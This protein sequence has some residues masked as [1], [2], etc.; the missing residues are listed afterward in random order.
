MCHFHWIFLTIEKKF[1]LL[2]YYQITFF[3]FVELLDTAKTKSGSCVACGVND[4]LLLVSLSHLS[5]LGHFLGLGFIAKTQQMS[6]KE[7]AILM[8]TCKAKRFSKVVFLKSGNKPFLDE[9]KIY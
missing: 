5:R 9:V 7:C 8:P 2:I 6:N 4:F 1:P 3:T